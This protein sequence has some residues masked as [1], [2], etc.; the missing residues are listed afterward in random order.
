MGI[1]TT[2]ATIATIIDVD[3][4]TTTIIGGATSR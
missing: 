1:T 3:I 4:R 2:T